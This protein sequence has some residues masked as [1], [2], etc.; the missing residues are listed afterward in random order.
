MTNSDVIITVTNTK[1][2]LFPDEASLFKGK[3]F[4]GIGSYKPEMREYPETF[5][6]QLEK[7]YIDTE[8]AFKETGDLIT[9][10]KQGWIKKEQVISIAKAIEN[11]QKINKSD[12]SFFKSVGMAL[13]DV[14]TTDL[15]YR[16]ALE[17]KIGTNVN[18]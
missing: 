13:F 12:T 8:H 10:I 16:K 11:S 4:V 18:I 5:F 3:H 14:V 2:P 7:I 6:K 15:I 1:T 9:P 17:Q